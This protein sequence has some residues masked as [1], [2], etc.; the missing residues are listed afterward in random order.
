MNINDNCGKNF[1]F[2]LENGSDDYLFVLFK[3][4]CTVYTEKGY[5]EVLPGSFAVFDKNLRQEYFS[6]EHDFVHD[7]IRF[8]FDKSS[9]QIFLPNIKMHTIFQNKYW[10]NISDIVKLTAVEFYS[11]YKHKDNSLN[12]LL[13]LLLT[14]M[15]EYSNNHIDSKS[16]KYYGKLVKIRADIYSN[17]QNYKSVDDVADSVHLSK[18][19][20]QALYKKFFSISCIDDIINAK[21]EKSKS[22]LSNTNITISEISYL[23]G[24]ANIEHFTRQ[25]KKF[26]SFTPSKYRKFSR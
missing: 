12:F 4:Q 22:L 11:N 3:S 1:R 20:L 23:C 14:K 17:P 16:S 15:V 5:V 7:F 10:E 24:Y 6:K 8:N 9:E 18:S 25:F 13:K 2:C 26:T 19:Y 21:I